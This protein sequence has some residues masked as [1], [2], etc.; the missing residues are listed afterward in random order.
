MAFI[1]LNGEDIEGV[2]N[3]NSPDA[4]SGLRKYTMPK[5]SVIALTYC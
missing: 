2:K 3:R 1:I 5:Y 4:T